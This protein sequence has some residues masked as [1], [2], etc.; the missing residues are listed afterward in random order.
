MG[1]QLQE[2]WLARRSFSVGGAKMTALFLPIEPICVEQH[3]YFLR[4]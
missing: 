2:K 3:H 1:A 4:K